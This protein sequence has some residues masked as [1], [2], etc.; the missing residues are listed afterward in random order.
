MKTGERPDGEK[1][2]SSISS[3]RPH[4]CCKLHCHLQK[5]PRSLRHLMKLH[6]LA[7][8]RPS[9]PMKLVWFLSASFDLVSRSWKRRRARVVGMKRISSLSYSFHAKRPDLLMCHPNK[10]VWHFRETSIETALI[11]LRCSL[12]SFLMTSMVALIHGLSARNH[13]LHWKM[14]CSRLT[15]CLIPIGSVFG[16]P[17]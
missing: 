10:C 9:L 2:S 7:P 8:E 3:V 5:S 13:S 14:T 16:G 11:G 1:K 12:A 15:R 17:L 6:C 4:C